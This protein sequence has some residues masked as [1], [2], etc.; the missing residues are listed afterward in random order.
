LVDA[1]AE[2]V[3]RQDFTTVDGIR[4]SNIVFNDVCIDAD[5]LV[6]E[7]GAA[8][9]DVLR[10]AITLQCAEAIGAMEVLLETTLQY[11]RDRQQFGKP[12]GQFQVLQHRMADMFMSLEHSKSVLF[13]TASLIDEGRCSDRDVSILK[14]QIAEAGAFIGGQAIQIH[15]GIGMT[16]EL[17]VGHYFKR[18]T[19]AAARFGSASWH[20]QIVGAP[21]V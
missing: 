17:D 7:E 8:L 9:A 14:I 12:I 20:A 15:G 3:Q 5:A 6:L 16:D 2:G 13:A 1:T 10:R 18:L 19:A 4:S 21:T 11:A